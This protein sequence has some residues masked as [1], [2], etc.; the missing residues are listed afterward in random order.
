MKEKIKL[1]ENYKGVKLLILGE[2]NSGKSSLAKAIDDSLTVSYDAKP[3][4]FEKPHITLKDGFTTQSI[5]ETVADAIDR[6]EAKFKELPRTMIFDAVSRIFME[7]EDVCQRKYNGFDVW[8]NLLKE[9]NKLVK[10]FNNDLIDNGFNV[11][12]VGHTTIDAETKMFREVLS[13]KFKDT[14]FISTVDECIYTEFKAKKYQVTHRKHPLART[15]LEE[16]PDT[17]PTDNFNINDY[18]NKLIEKQIS[19]ANNNWEI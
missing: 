18:F 10:F 11:V 4:P 8:S 9:T 7:L 17:Q 5:M 15:F 1:P 2:K 3:Y 16:L 13:G 6:Y 19:I 14:G 12:L